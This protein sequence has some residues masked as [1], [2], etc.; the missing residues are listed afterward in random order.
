MLLKQHNR[1]ITP[2][3]V[4]KRFEH[5]CGCQHIHMNSYAVGLDRSTAVPRFWL[6]HG[7][8]N[9]HLKARL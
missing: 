8:K 6:E 4:A 9:L 3:Q 1:V 2:W 7:G 5:T